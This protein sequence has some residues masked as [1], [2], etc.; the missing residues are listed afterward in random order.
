MLCL[1]IL[2]TEHVRKTKI[3]KLSSKRLVLAER[4]HQILSP[5]AKK[6][7]TAGTNKK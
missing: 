1:K 7:Q 6:I 2:G 3:P 4:P 5:V